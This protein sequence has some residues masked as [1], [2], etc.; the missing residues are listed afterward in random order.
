MEVSD[1]STDDFRPGPDVESD[2]VLKLVQAFRHLLLK[3]LEVLAGNLY[4]TYFKHMLKK[5]PHFSLKR[6]AQFFAKHVRP[7]MTAH[8]KF[9]E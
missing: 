5:F 6:W 7:L 2:P 9:E 8:E 4:I 3:L 1:C